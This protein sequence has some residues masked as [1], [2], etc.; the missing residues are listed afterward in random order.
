MKFVLNERLHGVLKILWY[1]RIVMKIIETPGCGELKKTCESFLKEWENDSDEII[2]T[3]SG[4][5]GK[6]KTMKFKKQWLLNS[7]KMTGGY[8]QLK[9]N[10][11][12]LLCMSPEFVAGKMM[13]V[14]ALMHNMNLLLAPVNANPLK[15]VTVEKIDFAAMVPLQ[16]KTILKENPDKLK[17]IRQLIIGGAPLLQTEIKAVQNYDISVYETFGMTETLSHVALKAIKNNNNIFHG[18]G[19]VSFSSNKDCLVIHAPMLGQPALQTN[20][21]IKL[22][23]SQSFIWKGRAD[24]VIN[25]GGVKVHPEEVEKLLETLLP[26][27]RFFVCGLKDKHLGEKVTLI[28]EKDLVITP[29]E[30]DQ[31]FQSHPYWKPRE[32]I[33][34]SK[35]VKTANNKIN[36][37]ATLKSIEIE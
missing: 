20:D 22:L 17:K 24:F 12:A 15:N 5:T 3:T 8:F 33:Y 10:Q 13:I 18:I 32:I 31:L 19:D 37:L 2:L 26:S 25:S 7:A 9:A 23:T 36:R 16:I 34:L 6:S 4:S 21:V 14:R 1:I 30:L 29:E 27:D 11:T 28:C 35:I